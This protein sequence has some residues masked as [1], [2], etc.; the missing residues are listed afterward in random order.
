MQKV[1]ANR[2][3]RR[4]L[5]IQDA[6]PVRD[7]LAWGKALGCDQAWIVTDIDKKAA[8]AL[9]QERGAAV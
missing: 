1:V 4:R 3:V 8:R 9:Y 7:L 2:S 5:E 6:V